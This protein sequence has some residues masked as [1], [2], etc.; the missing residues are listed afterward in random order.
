MSLTHELLDLFVEKSGKGLTSFEIAMKLPT[1]TPSKI[2]SRLRKEYPGI[3]FPH[4]V[5]TYGG[6]RFYRY[7][8][9]Y[10]APDE[11]V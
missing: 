11:A 1:S 6:R 4:T 10:A 7:Y 5:E 9:D 2:I 3:K 8:I